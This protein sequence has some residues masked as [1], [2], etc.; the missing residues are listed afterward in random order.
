MP[1]KKPTALRADSK[2]SKELTAARKAGELSVTPS[3]KLTITPPAELKGKNIACLEWRRVIELQETT[4]AAKDGAPI[5]TAF[6]E[7][8]L[9]TYCKGVQEEQTL[10]IKLDKLDKAQNVL[11]F[12]AS[13]I[14]PTKDNFK[15][16]VSMWTQFNGVTA[17]YKGM[18]A[19]LDA[20]RANL[21]ELAKS[22]YLTPSSRAG[23]APPRKEPEKPKSEMEKL[24]SGEGNNGN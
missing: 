20:H 15:N 19:R 18:S 4:Q 24:L 12:R 1:K 3:T 14:K 21:H 11:Y 2:D 17:N 7:R 16:F 23:V 8:S 6:D 9:I 10:E 13:K 22:M 5:I